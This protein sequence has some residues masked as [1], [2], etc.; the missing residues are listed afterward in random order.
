MEQIKESSALTSVSA[1]QGLIS[2]I[3]QVYDLYQGYR[4][5]WTLR[6]KPIYF[7]WDFYCVCRP[8]CVDLDWA[9]PTTPCL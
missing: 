1:S 4:T 3:C 6:V 2:I 5:G 8:L 9:D 7:Q